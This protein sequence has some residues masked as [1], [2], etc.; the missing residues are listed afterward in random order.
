[1]VAILLLSERETGRDRYSRKIDAIEAIEIAA[2]RALC[3]RVACFPGEHDEAADREV[4]AGE[5]VEHG[6]PG[7]RLELVG[8]DVERLE[9]DEVT[10]LVEAV[11]HEPGAGADVCRPRRGN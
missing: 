9:V 4:D 3:P 11:L 10:D 7:L 5:G 6:R 2:H 8:G 1:M